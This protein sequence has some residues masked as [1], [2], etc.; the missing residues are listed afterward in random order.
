LRRNAA[1]RNSAVA[2]QLIGLSHNYYNNIINTQHYT[3]RYHTT[4]YKSWRG[5]AAI[6]GA[7]AG[8]KEYNTFLGMHYFSA[9]AILLGEHKISLRMQCVPEKSSTK[10]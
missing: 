1:V 6:D 9:N 8:G 7:G 10:P 5:G 3:L 2:D 4:T